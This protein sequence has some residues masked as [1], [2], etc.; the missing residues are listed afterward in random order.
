VVL[1][2]LGIVLPP[3]PMKDK[4]FQNMGCESWGAGHLEKCGRHI[5]SQDQFIGK[6]SPGEWALI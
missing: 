5:A 2:L 6:E 4:G 1:V 3:D